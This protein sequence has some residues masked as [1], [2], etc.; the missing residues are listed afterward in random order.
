MNGE[1]SN[2]ILPIKSLLENLK[3]ESKKQYLQLDNKTT[4]GNV[5]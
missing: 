1:S 5:H 2:R 4:T 3:Q